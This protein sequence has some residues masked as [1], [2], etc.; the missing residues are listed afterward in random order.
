MNK[1]ET[2]SVFERAAERYHRDRGYRILTRNFR[3]RNG[4]IDLIAEDGGCLVFV[5]VKYRSGPG[6][7]DPLESVTPHKV[8]QITRAAQYFL[9]RMGYPEDTA[10]R[11]DVIGISEG[12]LRHVKNAFDASSQR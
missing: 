9:Y 12:R 2:G 7:G 1:R 8:R 3:H 6:A 11:F 10:C 4:E 5:E